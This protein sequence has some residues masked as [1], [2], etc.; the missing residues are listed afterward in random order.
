MQELRDA[1]RSGTSLDELWKVAR[2]EI[3]YKD[4][5]AGRK[6]KPSKRQESKKD[7]PRVPDD[8]VWV[9]SRQ[10]H[11]H[12][13]NVYP[14]HTPP[15]TDGLPSRAQLSPKA[16]QAWVLAPIHVSIL[17]DTEYFLMRFCATEAGQVHRLD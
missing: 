9:S 6:P 2:G 4:F 16:L 13:M 11:V 12:T 15:V 5:S 17:S 8:L 14:D 1:L 10:S 3:K 7:V